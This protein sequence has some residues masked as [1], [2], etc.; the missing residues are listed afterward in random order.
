MHGIASETY[1]NAFRL[2][3]RAEPDAGDEVGVVVGSHLVACRGVSW[4][5]DFAASNT[6]RAIA[7]AGGPSKCSGDYI[8]YNSARHNSAD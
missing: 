2:D 3:A 4:S 5:F 1:V 8:A 6:A 7:V